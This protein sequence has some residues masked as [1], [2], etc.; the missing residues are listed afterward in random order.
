MEI[1]NTIALQK[2]L[3]VKTQPAS[4]CSA[5]FKIEAKEYWN[6][7]IDHHST[8]NDH[9]VGTCRMGFGIQDKSAVVDSKFK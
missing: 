2:A 7:V 1:F 8:S 3:G 4:L 5:K 6:C 9:A